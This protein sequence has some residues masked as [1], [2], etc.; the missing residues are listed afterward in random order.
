V[1]QKAG[2]D[3]EKHYCFELLNQTD[4]ANL[5]MQ[6]I[7]E[8]RHGVKLRKV[9]ERPYEIR[10]HIEFELTPFEILLDQ[11]RA[12]KYHLKKVNMDRSLA[13]QVKKDARDIILEFIRSRPPLKKSSA[14]KLNKVKSQPANLHE[15][16]M[17]SIRNYE[18]PSL[19]KTTTVNKSRS[20]EFAKL[21]GNGEAAV[22]AKVPKRLLKVDTNLLNNLT[23]SDDVLHF[24]I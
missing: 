5:W 3:T 1:L 2:K 19:R 13:P 16:L 23:S 12:R 20:S 4:W 8:L 10:R 9:C 21:G 17:N 6:V 24:Y 15:Q 18:I 22:E 11:I 14:R 7:H